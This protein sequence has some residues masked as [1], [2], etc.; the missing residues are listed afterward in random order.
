MDRETTSGGHGASDAELKQWLGELC[1]IVV[2]VLKLP[3]PMEKAADRALEAVSVGIALRWVEMLGIGRA[4][5]IRLMAQNVPDAAAKL[6]SPQGQRALR[7]WEANHRVR[8]VLR[9]LEQAVNRI[10]AFWRLGGHPRRA[11]IRALA[12]LSVS[13]LISDAAR[14]REQ[15]AD[16]MGTESDA[17]HLVEGYAAITVD[18]KPEKTESIDGLISGS[19]P[20]GQWVR[21]LW[22]CLRLRSQKTRR[23]PA[24]DFES[25]HPLWRLSLILRE[26][27][28]IKGKPR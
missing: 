9:A 28:A 26:V 3:R 24:T 14:F 7:S 16:V 20:F 11:V 17:G 19:V 12:A 13:Q 23:I 6:S 22:V 10:L 1:P 18:N 2:R 15:L 8:P 4:A 21:S 25:C 27:A 5:K